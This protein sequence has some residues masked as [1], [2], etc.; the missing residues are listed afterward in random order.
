MMDVVRQK[1]EELKIEFIKLH[2]LRN[3][4]NKIE[5]IDVLRILIDKITTI[6]DDEK[7]EYVFFYC[8]LITKL[9]LVIKTV[10]ELLYID[11]AKRL[12][13]YLEEK[14]EVI[15]W[16]LYDLLEEKEVRQEDFFLERVEKTEEMI[17]EYD[18][19]KEKKL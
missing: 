10:Y 1:L 7:E 6:I 13:E 9:E 3:Y 16:I 15:L 18:L 17:D 12:I 11:D 8:L 5:A 4:K 14:E 19:R 2:M